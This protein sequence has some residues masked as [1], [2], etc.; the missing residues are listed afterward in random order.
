MACQ[1]PTLTILVPLRVKSQISETRFGKTW[2]WVKEARWE[3]CL[4]SSTTQWSL[5]HLIVKIGPFESSC[6]RTIVL[7]GYCT[8]SKIIKNKTKTTKK[9]EVAIILLSH[10]KSPL[11][12]LGIKHKLVN[13][14]TMQ[15]FHVT[16]RISLRKEYFPPYPAS[17]T[18]QSKP[19][20]FEGKKLFQFVFYFAW[21]VYHQM[22]M[23]WLFYSPWQC[24]I[25]PY[26][27]L[28]REHR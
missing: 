9:G 21:H 10:T 28:K 4:A 25:C 12:W 27:S 26:A 17:F 16:L 18:L 7:L 3:K 15:I 8:K 6:A 13:Q 5:P 2:P 14:T 20:L 24:S 22:D 19:I 23:T 11:E 1:C